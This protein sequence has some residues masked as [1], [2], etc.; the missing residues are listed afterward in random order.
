[1]K[2]HRIAI[3]GLGQRI[4][5]VLAAM[6]EVGWRPDIAGYADPAPVGASILKDHDIAPGRAYASHEALLKDG[7]FDLVMIGSPNHLHLEHLMAAFQA[8]YPM[9]QVDPIR[10]TVLGT[11]TV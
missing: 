9:F 11:L 5:H 1:M 6:K 10:R 4:A 7:P 8:G 3:I 2:S